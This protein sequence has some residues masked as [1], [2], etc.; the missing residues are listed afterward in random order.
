VRRFLSK[1]GNISGGYTFG[2]GTHNFIDTLIG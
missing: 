2:K 1:D